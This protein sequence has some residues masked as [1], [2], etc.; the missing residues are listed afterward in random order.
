MRLI[1]VY[2]LAF[3]AAISIG[4]ILYLKAV[5]IWLN[6]IELLV[7]CIMIGGIGGIMYCLRA[8]YVNAC[9]KKSWEEDSHTVVFYK[10]VCQFDFRWD[11]L[12]VS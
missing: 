5:P 9:V 12:F 10:T 2:L 6:N 3:L 4:W 11:K 8:V 1:I 7:N